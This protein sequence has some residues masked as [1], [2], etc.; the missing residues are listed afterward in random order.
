MVLPKYKDDAEDIRKLLEL[1]SQPKQY[2]VKKQ[3]TNPEIDNFISENNILSGKKRIPSYIVYYKYYLWKQKR[4]IQR[5]KFFDYF[6]TKFE[7]TRTI[8]GIGF[9]LSPKGFD[10]TPGGYFRARKLLREENEKKQKT[11]K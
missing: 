6:K 11:V 3:K 7:K 5:R 8:D 1:A 2:R 9:L 10:M 4:L